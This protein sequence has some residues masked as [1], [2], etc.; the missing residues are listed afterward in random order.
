MLGVGSHCDARENTDGNQETDYLFIVA[1][2]VH[3]RM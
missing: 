1:F 2:L 3:K